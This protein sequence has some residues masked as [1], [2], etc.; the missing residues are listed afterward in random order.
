VKQVRQRRRNIIW[1]PS[2]VE[3]KKKWYKWTCK[4]ETHRLRKWTY[5]CWGE[6]LG[7]RDS[8]GVRARHVHTAVFKRITNRDLLYST[9]N[10][11][12]CYVAGWMGG[13]VWRGMDTWICM[14]ESLP[15]SPKTITMLLIG[16]TP[17]QNK[18]FKK[19]K[20]SGWSYILFLL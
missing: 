14:A 16:Y 18:K 3:S 8:W 6:G 2:C 1:H 5:G 15:C 19:S 11:A 12:Q 20:L 13:G 9:W 17:I 4:T 7:D 10:S